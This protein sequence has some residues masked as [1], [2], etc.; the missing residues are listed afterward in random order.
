MKQG[1]S[2]VF[3]LILIG[4]GFPTREL[5]KMQALL[6]HFETHQPVF[7]SIKPFLWTHY[8]SLPETDGDTEED[9]QLPFKSPN[10]T[11]LGDCIPTDMVTLIK[12]PFKPISLPFSSVINGRNMHRIPEKYGILRAQ[13]EFTPDQTTPFKP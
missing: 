9:M 4:G 12:S 2:I 3:L 10:S 7:H 6:R 8:V 5:L 11:S 1:I 13:P